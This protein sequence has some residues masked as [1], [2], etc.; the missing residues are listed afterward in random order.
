VTKKEFLALMRFPVEWDTLGMYPDDLFSW[1][2]SGY[3]PGHEQG[4]EHDR[5]GAFHW[6]LRRHPSK[7]QLLNLV[8]LAALDP[9][10]ALGNDVRQYFYAAKSFDSEVASLDRSLFGALLPRR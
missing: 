5:N 10:D 4:A 9:D 8:R 6:W 1:Q 2:I 7:A 3:A